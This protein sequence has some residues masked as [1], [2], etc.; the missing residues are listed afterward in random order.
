MSA[1]RVNKIHTAFRQSGQRNTRQRRLIEERFIE[2]AR[3][4]EVF[5][6]DDLWHGLRQREPHLGR[7][8]LY[9]AIEMLVSMKVLDRIDFADGTH[10]Y[11]V[12]G[13]EEHQHLTCV[14]CHTVVE[15]CLSLPKEQLTRISTQNKFVLEGLS[16]TLFG[17]C[18]MCKKT[19]EGMLR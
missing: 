1:D 8:T 18:A 5:A 2:L 11:R 17:R 16:L 10:H 7:S 6:I 13:G 3:T 4:G 9:R 12:C 19:L 14:R 15:V